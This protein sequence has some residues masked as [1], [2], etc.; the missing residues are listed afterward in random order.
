M[1]AKSPSTEISEP[2]K[3]KE[4]NTSA[5]TIMIGTKELTIKEPIIVEKPAGSNKDVAVF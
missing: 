2:S 3:Q 4:E 1:G 5:E